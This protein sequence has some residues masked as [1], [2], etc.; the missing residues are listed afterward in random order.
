MNRLLPL[1]TLAALVLVALPAPTATAAGELVDECVVYYVADYH[2]YYTCVDPKDPSCAV[3]TQERHGVTW[4]PK[5]CVVGVGVTI[6]APEPVC[7]PTNGGGMDY[8][9]QACA[10]DGPRRCLLSHEGSTDYTGYYY[11]CYAPLP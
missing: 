3:Y 4:T 9:S 5:E 7:V 11:T 8:Y 1:A 6:A 10:L 2:W